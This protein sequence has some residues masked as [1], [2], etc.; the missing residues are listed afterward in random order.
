MGKMEYLDALKRAMTGLPPE[1][2]A[3]TLA[4]YE[5]RFVDGLAAGRSEDDVGRELDDPKKI[6]MTLRA[7]A[8]LSAF[9]EKKNPANMLRLLVSSVGLAIF[10]LFMV[11]PAAVYA[12]LLTALYACALA[13]YV[14]G[15][16]ITASGLA[17]ANELVLGEPLRHVTGAEGPVQTRITVGP[18]GIQFYTEPADATRDGS[19]DDESGSRVMRGAEQMAGSRVHI[20]TD[21]DPEARTTQ[22][23]VGLG[24]VLAG[25][26]LFLLSLV[27]TRYTFI[28]IR[29]YIQMNLSLLKGS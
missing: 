7:S 2:Q 5:Q 12:S 20:S 17:G 27:V 9:N 25:I 19:A 4:Y 16:A 1:T 29:R 26:A 21:M 8:H 18:G 24:M 22:T 28:G 6:A 15:I 23:V 11:I 3:R 10:N 13:M 14:A